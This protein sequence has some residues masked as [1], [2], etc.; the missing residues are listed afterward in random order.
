MNL[1][2]IGAL[3]GFLAVAFGAFGT[4]AL[5]ERLPPEMLRIWQT[6]TQYQLIHSVMTCFCGWASVSSSSRKVEIAGWLF[7]VGIIVFSGSLYV[8]ALTEIRVL[9]AV[10]P[11]GGLSILAGWF[12]TAWGST[13]LKPRS[14]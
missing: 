2:R 11:L 9:G 7:V 13:E 14:G 10:T 3:L 5:Q 1:Y 12:L 4:H 6:G 8:L